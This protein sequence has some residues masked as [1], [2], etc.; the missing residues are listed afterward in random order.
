MQSIAQ[1]EAAD[2]TDDNEGVNDE[3]DHYESPG[4]LKIKREGK[5]NAAKEQ[6]FCGFKVEK[7]KMPSFSGD[8]REYAIC[9]SDFKHA[10]EAR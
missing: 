3:K 5:E 1:R 9:R 6:Q 7:P 2:E 10:I 4:G 8:V